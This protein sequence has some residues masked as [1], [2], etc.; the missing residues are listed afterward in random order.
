V[1][2]PP[3]EPGRF[4]RLS[5]A[6]AVAFAGVWS[7]AALAGLTSRD[8]LPAPWDVL[9]RF[10]QLLVEP[11]GKG[12]RR[13]VAAGGGQQRIGR[14]QESRIDRVDVHRSLPISSALSAIERAMASARTFAS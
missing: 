8:F 4:W 2:Q 7:A 12:L 3:L 5:A 9:Q 6:G 14:G 10:A 11:G 1:I 13:R